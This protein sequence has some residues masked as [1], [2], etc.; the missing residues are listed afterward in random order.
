MCNTRNDLKQPGFWDELK[1]E[2]KYSAVG[3]KATDADAV[4]IDKDFFLS[5]A[6]QMGGDLVKIAKE[7]GLK[8]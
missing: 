6:N 4:V 7:L 3:Q 2:D 8:K 1:Q 5:L